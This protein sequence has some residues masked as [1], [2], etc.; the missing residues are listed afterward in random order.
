MNPKMKNENSFLSKPGLPHL[1][2]FKHEN[3]HFAVVRFMAKISA[4]VHDMH[5]K[6]FIQ[7]L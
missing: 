1:S 4:N 5:K 2:S 3:N 6:G 7:I